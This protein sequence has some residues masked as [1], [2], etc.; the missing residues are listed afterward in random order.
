MGSEVQ[1]AFVLLMSWMCRSGGMDAPVL[2]VVYDMWI[3][4]VF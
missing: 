4:Q 3:R 2:E 1:R